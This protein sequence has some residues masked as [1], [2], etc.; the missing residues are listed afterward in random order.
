VIGLALLAADWDE[1]DLDLIRHIALLSGTFGP[2]AARAL[3][4]R[5]GGSEALL[6]LAQRTAGCGRVY[7]VEALCQVAG[8]SVRPW[9]LRNGSDGD[10]LNGYYVGTSHL[11][12]TSTRR[13]P[14]PIP[15]TN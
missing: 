10:F 14:P 7:I 11:P 5:R 2:L 4:R 13:S 6:W 1:R 15:T 9:L 3:R 12:L 8:R